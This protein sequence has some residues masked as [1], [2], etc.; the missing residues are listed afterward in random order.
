MVNKIATKQ[1]GDELQIPE[2]IS[3]AFPIVFEAR[4]VQMKK[5]IGMPFTNR[6][7]VS[8]ELSLPS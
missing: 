6:N 2:M 4:A 5:V 1:A 8:F 7:L 3:C